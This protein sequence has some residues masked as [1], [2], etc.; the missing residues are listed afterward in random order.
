MFESLM[1]VLESLASVSD[2]LENT[3]VFASIP[4]GGY[5]QLPPGIQLSSNFLV[6]CPF[7]PDSTPGP[8]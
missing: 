1:F 6:I 5:T 2:E 4:E 3:G 7:D 8:T